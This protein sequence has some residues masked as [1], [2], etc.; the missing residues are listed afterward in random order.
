MSLLD[1]LAKCAFPNEKSKPRFVK[2]I[3]SF[4]DW[5]DKDRYSLR[6][7]QFCL[8]NIN[9]E[10]KYPKL[11]ALRNV[12]Q[13]RMNS[14]PQSR[15][16]PKPRDVDPSRIDLEEV[17][18]AKLSEFI[19]QVRYPSLLWTTRNFA[20]HE[21]RHPGEGMDFGNGEPTPYYHELMHM[22][23][24]RETWELYF[25]TVLNSKLITD[26]SKN[27]RAEFLEKQ[28]DILARFESK[29]DWYTGN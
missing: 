22:P 9:D 6:Q 25:P 14:W 15:E 23:S 21:L 12:V 19:E 18:D 10:S 24:G 5:E 2:L 20:V 3:D 17:L 27:L 13:S 8:Q 29:P 7:L 1:L 16:L 26:S 11:S 4:S 28:V